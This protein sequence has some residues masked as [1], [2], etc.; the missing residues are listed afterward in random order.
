MLEEKE[1]QVK[2]FKSLLLCAKKNYN[3]ENHCSCYKNENNFCTNVYGI[4]QYQAFVHLL[5][6]LHIQLCSNF[7]FLITKSVFLILHS[8]YNDKFTADVYF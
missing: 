6:C 1:C 2:F 8:I 4:V 5:V 7:K 3:K